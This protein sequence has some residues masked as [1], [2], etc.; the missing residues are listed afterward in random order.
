MSQG[1]V[2]VVTAM[3]SLLVMSG[4]CSLLETDSP[5]DDAAAF[6]RA[7]SEGKLSSVPVAEGTAAR[8]QRWWD[9]TR[10]GMGDSTQKV[11][12]EKLREG[13]GDT[14]T[15]V[16]A[17]TWRLDSSSV[18]WTY[19]T[20]A[21]LVRRGDA[22]AVDLSPDAVVP[23]LKA[24]ERL[25][26]TKLAAERADIIGADGRH[27]VTDRPVVRVG[28]D[29]TLG[30]ADQHGES[31]R[32]LARVLDI[33]ADSFAER[34][35]AAPAKAFVEALVLREEDVTQEIERGYAAIP[36]VRALEDQVPLA[37]T[38]EFARAILGTVG[39]VTA[40]MVEKSKGRYAVGDVAGLSGLQQRYDDQLGGRPGWLVQAVG[41][42]SDQ[43][44]E[45]F[46]AEPEAGKQLRVTLDQDL[47]TE[48]ERLLAP[49]KPA[50]AIVAI[51]PSTGEVLA[52]ANGPGSEGYATSTLGQYAPGSTFKVVSSLA[53]LRSGLT[54]EDPVACPRT[55]VVDGKE[56]GNYSDYPSSA[57][58]RIT[59]RE[60]VAQSC[61]TAFI[62]LRERVSAEELAEA[63]EALGL[64]KDY[65]VGFP[66]YFGSVPERGTA[67]GHAAS[68]IGQGQVVASPMAMAAVAG[69][70]AAGETV[71]PRL[72]ADTEVEPSP[73]TPLTRGEA[74]QLRRLMAAVV[75]QGSGRFLSDVGGEQVLAKTGTAE[76]GDAEPPLTHAWM[77]GGQGD[78]AVAVF[79]DVGES[80]SQT[81]GP[82]LEQ[83]LRAARP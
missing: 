42:R 57:L 58:G 30:R 20:T 62:S 66:A 34:V 32:E 59:L 10:E 64:G 49:M 63:A 8:A 65:D 53:L 78:L 19:R 54:A 80:G 44:R 35:E 1:R 46:R 28:I 7:L 12:V 5:E 11:R 39:P 18:E 72:I 9:R 29:K 43:Q 15:A 47:Q 61:N 79:V 77:I 4:G 38:R 13:E 31:A 2:A 33:D 3:A 75:E 76:F 71:V 41:D 21:T 14:A 23:G 26:L 51:R 50:S 52:A 74:E 40:E 83:F 81:A 24:G 67:T 22:W 60:A 73:A 17:H 55:T 6:A 37:P 16:L 36:A 56:F 25:R 70:V 69:S 45:L 68:L 48:A 82:L 27:L